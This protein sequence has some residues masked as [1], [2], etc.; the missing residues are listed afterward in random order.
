MLASTSNIFTERLIFSSTSLSNDNLYFYGG[1]YPE[2]NNSSISI[3]AQFSFKFNFSKLKFKLIKSAIYNFSDKPLDFS[4]HS[5]II[6]NKQLIIFGGKT[7]QHDI[8]R[9]IYSLDL[10][11]G[12]WTK[13]EFLGNKKKVKSRAA[14]TSILIQNKM[15]VFGGYEGLNTDNVDLNDLFVV[16]VDDFSF[17]SLPLQNEP[18]PRCFH[19]CIPW[20]DDF[21]IFGGKS[22]F[23]G[24]DVW[25]ND[26]HICDFKLWR[27]LKPIGKFPIE[28]AGH[29]SHLLD[30]QMMIFGGESSEGNSLNDCWFYDLKLNH[31]KEIIL[32]FDITPRYG[33][34]SVLKNETLYIFGGLRSKKFVYSQ[35]DFL[36]DVLKID[37]GVSFMAP[38]SHFSDTIFKFQ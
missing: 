32:S 19:S 7:S 37:F 16:N 18:S 2:N 10:E 26:I 13:K 3:S 27:E 12:F 24:K 22:C 38:S 6:Y 34:S 29:C 8:S 9:K 21:I 25:F 1:K 4:Q 23:E 14:H 15:I 30:H 5:S 17:Y 28:R 33:F 36:S 11:T 35:S 31:W 20:K